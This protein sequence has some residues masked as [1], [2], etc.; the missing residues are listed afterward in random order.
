MIHIST[1]KEEQ[2]NLATKFVEERLGIPVKKTVLKNT[3]LLVYSSPVNVS[4]LIELGRRGVDIFVLKISEGG[5]VIE[6]LLIMDQIHRVS[7]SALRNLVRIYPLL[8]SEIL[9]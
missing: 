5:K 2:V 8:A 7:E 6:A 1:I 9:M 3:A 4:L